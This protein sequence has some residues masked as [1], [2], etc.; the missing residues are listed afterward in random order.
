MHVQKH[1]WQHASDFK[2]LEACMFHHHLRIAENKEQNLLDNAN[3]KE[4]A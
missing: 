3:K 4:A 1:I 2:T